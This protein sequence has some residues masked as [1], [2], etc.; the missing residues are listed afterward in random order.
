[1]LS[2]R[3]F[4]SLFG[5]ALKAPQSS[6][7]RVSM[8]TLLNKPKGL[9]KPTKVRRKRV[10]ESLKKKTKKLGKKMVSGKMRTIYK[11][12]RGARF[13]RSRNGKKTYI[14]KTGSR[15]GS[16]ATQFS[17]ATLPHGQAMFGRP[18]RQNNGKRHRLTNKPKRK[19]NKSVKSGTNSALLRHPQLQQ[20]QA[21]FGGRPTRQNNGKRHRLTNKPKRKPNKSVKSG[22]NNAFLEAM[23]ISQ[24]WGNIK[25]YYAPAKKATSPPKKVKTSPKPKR[26]VVRGFV[27]S[28]ESPKSRPTPEL[29]PSPDSSK[30]KRK[31]VRRSTSSSSSS[32]SPKKAK[33]KSPEKPKPKSPEKNKR[34]VVRRSTSSLGGLCLPASMGPS[35]PH[36][37]T[38]MPT[39]FGHLRRMGMGHGRAVSPMY[40]GPVF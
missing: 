38:M 39:G 35:N 29:L 10:T 21:M 33:P 19:P 20:L 4:F 2:K 7:S 13:Y 11:S 23:K 27:F 18:T 8:K 12:A 22:S 37:A 14:K 5:L 32:E 15:F 3:Q 34:K 30:P 26:K 24:I 36:F 1:M 40:H 17:S 16:C 25:S 31:V 28:S 9:N 6:R